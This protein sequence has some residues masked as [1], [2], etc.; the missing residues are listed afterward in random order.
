MVLEGEE[1]NLVK[2]AVGSPEKEKGQTD[3]VLYIY[4]CWLMHY[5][6]FG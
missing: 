5:Q 2:A 4:I 1:G 6:Y 3:E